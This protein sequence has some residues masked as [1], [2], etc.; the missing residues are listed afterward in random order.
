VEQPTRSPLNCSICNKPVAVEIAK[1]DDSGQAVHEECYALK[2]ESHRASVQ[3]RE[4][5]RTP[6]V[7]H[8]LSEKTRV[9]ENSLPLIVSSGSGD[10]KRALGELVQ[11][12]AESA[13][14]KFGSFYVV[15]RSENVLKPLVTYGLPQAYIEECGNVRIGDQCCG[16]AV[17]HRKP[18]TVSDMLSD[19]LFE[20][21]REAAMKSPIRAGFS[22]PVIDENGNCLGSL[23][24]QY[25][26]VHVA[27]PEEIVRNQ[28][29]AEMIAE[30]I[31]VYRSPKLV[32]DLSGN[33]AT[34]ERATSTSTSR[35][36][37]EATTEQPPERG[38]SS[39]NS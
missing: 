32:H 16:R 33:T 26:E 28:I 4:Q 19:P 13:H 8:S 37:S 5:E 23:A 27:T 11:M 29:W 35:T 24:S 14:S 9:F 39:T 17:Q 2:L 18:W 15:D 21:A 20:S 30:T 12:A 36:G 34:K 38:S 22:V 7:H 6:V 1:T 3:R 10:L 31:S 25:D